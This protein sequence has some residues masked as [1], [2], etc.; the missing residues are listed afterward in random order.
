MN[1]EQIITFLDK[2]TCCKGEKL[3]EI[4]EISSTFRNEF[5]FC[6]FFARRKELR[7]FVSERYDPNLSDEENWIQNEKIFIKKTYEPEDYTYEKI[8]EFVK[9]RIW[10]GRVCFGKKECQCEFY[11][12]ILELNK[13]CT[14]AHDQE[15]S[16]LNRCCNYM[17]TVGT[18]RG[19]PSCKSW[20][21]KRP[22]YNIKVSTLD[23]IYECI[24][25]RIDIDSIS[26][27]DKIL[28]ILIWLKLN[29][30]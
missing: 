6:E 27:E 10:V 19:T 8:R 15:F 21:S 1:I 16:K 29:E 20:F 23:N 7:K 11:V 26:L 24:P 17:E 25:E 5:V 22:N 2:H 28:S 14:F 18:R 9:Q 4:L 12:Y 3:E 13:V 30:N